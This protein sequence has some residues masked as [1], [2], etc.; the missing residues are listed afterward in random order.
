VTLKL[1]EAGCR[2]FGVSGDVSVV[3]VKKTGQPTW[4]STKAKTGDVAK[5]APKS[6]GYTPSRTIA[7]APIQLDPR[8]CFWVFL[9]WVKGGGAIRGKL[10]VTESFIVEINCGGAGM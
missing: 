7:V 5:M 6:Q 10:K 9:G 8:Y 2:S 3:R 4:I 1:R